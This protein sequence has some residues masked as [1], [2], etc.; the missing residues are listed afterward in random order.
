MA[1]ERGAHTPCQKPGRAR[2]VRS[3]F[4]KEERTPDVPRQWHFCELV[5][6]RAFFLWSLPSPRLSQL[7]HPV[8]KRASCRALLKKNHEAIKGCRWSRLKE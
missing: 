7:S 8:I 1:E 5:K 4:L 6:A 2:G 3:S